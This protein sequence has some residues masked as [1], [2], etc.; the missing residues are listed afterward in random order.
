MADA[1]A[2]PHTQIREHLSRSEQFEDNLLF[3][4]DPLRFD[5]L[6]EW[7]IGQLDFTDQY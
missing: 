5:F 7:R 6:D 3:D 1:D 4:I 2:L